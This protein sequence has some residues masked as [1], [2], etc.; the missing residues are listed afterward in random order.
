MPEHRQPESGVLLVDK[1]SGWTS[2]DVV[3]FIRRFGFRK[4]GHCGTL[5]PAATGLLV[6]VLGRATKLSSRLSGQDKTYE[7]TM[8]LGVETFTQD[9]EGEVVAE[10][11]WQHITPTRIRQTCARFV[12]EQQ[13]V[14]P[15]VSA[16]K[17]DG[18]ALYK[19]ARRGE[20]VRREPRTITIH[21][22]TVTDI[23]LPDVSL[24][25]KCSKG[26]YVR[27]LCADIGKALDCGAHLRTLRRTRSG[28]F[29]VVEAAPME[30]IRRWNKAQV[31]ARMIPLAQL[32]ARL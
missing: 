15:M 32:A 10:H 4:V 7:G 23:D 24:R 31:L 28:E 16:I 22:L 1:A 12:G 9:A 5:D 25:V 14:P 19:R 30:E 3:A 6:L 26:A 17:V 20:V 8:R 2:H 18:V 27:V 29:D 13:Q 11:E 21:E